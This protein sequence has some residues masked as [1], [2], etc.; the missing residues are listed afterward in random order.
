ML[1]ESSC[2]LPLWLTAGDRSSQGSCWPVQQHRH[3]C[4]F[5][6]GWMGVPGSPVIGFGENTSTTQRVPLTKASWIFPSA[7][8]SSSV[9]L[10]G[11]RR[12][13]F[14]CQGSNWGKEIPPPLLYLL[15]SFQ[16]SCCCG[17]LWRPKRFPAER[18]VLP[19][20]DYFLG[21]HYCARWRF[22]FLECFLCLLRCILLFA[23]WMMLENFSIAMRDQKGPN[24]VPLHTGAMC[25]SCIPHPKLGPVTSRCKMCCPVLSIPERATLGFFLCRHHHLVQSTGTSCFPFGFCSAIA[26]D[27][28]SWWNNWCLINE[29]LHGAVYSS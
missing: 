5:C 15:P 28:W 7:A 25:L 11:Q 12:S 21:V 1:P 4:I 29:P 14:H 22:F 27:H 23:F 24:P 26:I 9:C 6:R 10:L 3:P 13:S 18:C 17:A 20:R 2:S 8:L 16:S 19:A